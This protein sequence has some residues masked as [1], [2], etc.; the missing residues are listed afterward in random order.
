MVLADKPAQIWADLAGS[1]K[2]SGFGGRF[3]VFRW[4]VRA[5]GIV[6]Q[7][8]KHADSE[9]V[10]CRALIAHKDE[11][12]RLFQGLCVSILHLALFIKLSKHTRQCDEHLNV[13]ERAAG[14]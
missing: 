5:F 4:N 1:F 9:D 10:P 6:L 13:K 8:A 2:S 11:I 14:K 12:L 3:L 7:V